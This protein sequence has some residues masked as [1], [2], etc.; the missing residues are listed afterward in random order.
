MTYDTVATI[1]QVASLLM[2]IAMFAGRAR[3]RA[4]AEQQA[5]LRGG[6]AAA[7]SISSRR[8]TTTAGARDE[9]KREI[10]AVTGVE[11]TGHEWDGIKELNKP[12]PRWWLLHLLRH[13]SS[14]RSATGSSIRPGRRLT[15]Y[16]KGMLG[17]S[18][19]A[20]VADEVKAAQAAQGGM[21]D[22]L[23]KTPLADDQAA[24]RI[25]CASPSPAA[26]PRS[27]PTARPATAAARRASS[28]IPISTTTIG[29]GAARSTTSTRPSA[30]GIRSDQQGD[31]RLADA[32]LRPRQAAR[33]RARSTTPPSTCCR[34]PAN[35]PTRRRPTQGQKVFADQCATCHGDDGK[36]KHGAGRAQ[37][38]R[39]HLALRR[40]QGRRS[41]R[42]S[43]P[44][45]AA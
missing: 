35:R 3:L 28:A 31:A 41:S 33:G 20:T 38:D 32:A 4:L 34:S 11:T 43:A 22:K 10:D 7:R 44:A 15:G 40:Q 16:T 36:G 19:R 18:Q 25:C 21:R 17:Y 45:A 30:Y 5:A 2:F 42:A 27:R 6:A 13:A 37:P 24:T 29:S 39:R 14:G 9:H 1:S 12:L 8:P 23:A 26:A